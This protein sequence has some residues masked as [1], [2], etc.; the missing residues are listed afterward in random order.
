MKKKKWKDAN[1]ILHVGD[2]PKKLISFDKEMKKK[3]NFDHF[4]KKKKAKGNE[5]SRANSRFG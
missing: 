5:S 3:P 1:D 2:V 4:Q